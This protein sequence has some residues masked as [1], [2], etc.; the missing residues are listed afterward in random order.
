VDVDTSDLGAVAAELLQPDA[1]LQVAVRAGKRHVARW[2]H[3]AA[4]SK[5][6]LAIPGE[7]YR[8]RTSA[9][10]SLDRLTLVATERR[11][12]A[13]GEVELE[14]CASAINFKDVLHCLGML[15]DFSRKAGILRAVDQ[16]LGFECAGRVV[17]VGSGVEGLAV[18]DAVFTMAPSALA[19]HVTIDRRLVHRMPGNLSF[20]Q[21]A[22][23]PAA[24]MTAIYSL[25]KLA[26]LRPGETVLIHAC[27]GG[28]G[29]A[30]VQIAR[31]RGA[32]VF[33]T[34]SRAKW[35]HVKRQGVEHVMSSRTLDFADEL[36]RITEGRGVDVVL[37][38]LTG[39]FISKSADVLARGGR[40]VD[41]GK[42]GIWS[43][44]EMAAYRPDVAYFS[45]DLGDV[46]GN[47][48]LQVDLLADTVRGLEDGRLAPLPVKTFPIRQAEAGFRHLAQAK[49]IGKVVLTLPA[50]ERAAGAVRADRSYWVTG[51]LGALG[52]HIARSLVASGARQL[53]LS[54]RSEPG[55]SAREAVESLRAAGAEVVIE[56]MDV[57]DADQVAAVMRRIAAE[58]QPLGGIVHAAG[59]LDDGVLVKQTWPRFSRVLAPK[60]AGA[61][62]L[63]VAT[64]S[65][66]LDFF[67]L[68]SSVAAV[69]GAPG[70][71]NYAA[72]NAFLDGLAAL[73]RSQGLPA[74]SI[75]WGPWAA[76]GMAETTRAANR[77][78]FE[79]VG[80]GRMSVGDN[81]EVFEHLLHGASATVAVAD[82]D[83]TKF[84]KTV[85]SPGLARLYSQLGQGTAR[86][87][88]AQIGALLARLAQE[89]EER[90]EATLIDFLRHQVASV[91]GLASADTVEATQPLLELGFDSLM[92]VELKNRVEAS[93]GCTL[94]PALLFD[95]PTLELLGRH[96][97][98]DVLKLGPAGGN[99][100]SRAVA[101][102][103]AEEVATDG[104]APL[105]TLRESFI[106]AGDGTK[107]CVCSW[108]PGDA[109]LV[110]CVHGVLDQGASWDELAVGLVERGYRVVALDLRGHGRSGHHP[111]N[112]ASTVVD[113]LLDL[114]TVVDVATGATKR[115][116]TLVG[117]SMGG[118]VATLFASAYPEQV[119][120]L[121]LVEPVI[122]HLR[123]QQGALDLLKNELRY[124]TEPPAHTP[125][126]D[127]TT[128][129]RMLTLS[130][131]GLSTGRSLELAQRITEPCEGGL[132]WSW[133]ARLRNPLGVDLGFSRA[134]YLSL[135]GGLAVPSLR[136]YGTTSQFAGTPV[137]APSDMRV[138]RSRSV[139]ISG[140]HNLHTDN[141]A[142]LLSEVLTELDSETGSA[143]E[144]A[145]G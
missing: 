32:R 122:P 86:A 8:L 113:F 90:R 142:A 64:R 5:G 20:A 128:A 91:V 16:P 50:N 107:L 13:A 101:A 97:L 54:G 62:N 40:F 35:D 125:Y 52:L 58:L 120:R 49:N 118:A 100:G 31:A 127:L 11:E 53:V 26:R 22:S 60:V 132:R 136:L 30:A 65:L 143:P 6:Q 140:G 38:S 66:E 57:T 104:V 88:P 9:Y 103:P 41:I 2:A 14:V 17:R 71:G 130:H 45:F 67:V 99:A 72:A 7:S 42:I 102:A 109:P 78:R 80:L 81:V 36:L 43:T 115:P 37:N 116:F 84:L 141:A 138:P 39:A 79:S 21:A 24:F 51:G 108:G 28:V 73:R 117:H 68:F 98:V 129:A 89:P 63:H 3:A 135:L 92:A 23:I 131:G 34:A 44:A 18:G 134:H 139:S 12:P 114:T 111:A 137:L 1:E 124:R 76:G 94:S 56:R 46:D 83:W 87:E 145:T 4:Q 126:P 85:S 59:V 48:E 15:E 106:E 105:A 55:D 47:G 25:E 95:H 33:G 82:V 29:Q 96:L 27:A 70:Q 144:T 121:I 93:L 61:W 110:V 19:S 74:T 69:M 119:E 77:A 10:G 123:E 75:N 112:V 133:D